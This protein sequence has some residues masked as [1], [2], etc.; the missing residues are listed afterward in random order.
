MEA[1]SFA[2]LGST[3]EGQLGRLRAV[4]TTLP[5]DQRGSTYLGFVDRHLVA[6]DQLTSETQTSF[7]AGDDA[8]Q[9]IYG[10]KLARI[11]YLL[12][13]LHH[14]VFEYRADIGRRDLP[15][16]I[17]YLVDYLIAHLLKASADPLIHLNPM[18]MYSTQ[19][20]VHR[21]DRLSRE[22]GL[23]WDGPVEPVIFNLPGLDPGN[24]LLSPVLTHE[25]GHSVIQRNDLVSEVGARL[26][27]ATVDALKVE[28]LAADPEVKVDDALDQFARWAEELLCDALATEIT[29]PC[30]A[31][32]VAVFFPASAA[33]RSGPDH[34][35]PAQRFELALHQL[36]LNGWMPVLQ[37]LC[38]VTTAWL[39]TVAKVGPLSSPTPVET[40]LR[41]LVDLARIPIR[42][43]A[44]KYVGESLTWATFQP[45]EQQLSEML[46]EGLPPAELDSDPV[47]LWHI[48]TAIW[49]YS[50]TVHGDE[51]KGLVAAV[52]DHS[53]SRFALKA[54]EM[55]QV[56]RLWRDTDAPSS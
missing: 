41:K 14:E 18:Y 11:H 35:D 29:G 40:F 53:L 7:Q 10:R 38:P 47:P 39:K 22:L 28:L 20:L 37:Q 26:N 50:F 12:G 19:R 23:S 48:M 15:P 27:I 25:V 13:F 6:L 17:L 1:N 45:L 30:F 4:L 42:E 5:K 32:S 56:L 31:F 3:V 55:S 8:E 21:W 54:V 51:P 24:A 46:A 49:L 16:G 9:E 33:G 2:L 44:V 34:P 52:E 36:S 43:V